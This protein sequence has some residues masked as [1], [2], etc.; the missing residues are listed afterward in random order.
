MIARML[1]LL[2]LASPAPAVAQAPPASQPAERASAT[3]AGPEARLL[4]TEPVVTQHTIRIG[5]Q[6]VAY[7]AEA[8][9]LPI[10]EDGKDAA[11]MFYIR[12]RE[13]GQPAH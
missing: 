11:R 9:W 7:T 6:Q 5:T 1:A 4:P 3:K 2:L 13:V 10:R 8:G 12:V